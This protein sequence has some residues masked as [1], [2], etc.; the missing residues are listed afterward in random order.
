MAD[1]RDDRDDKWDVNDNALDAKLG[2]KKDEPANN[3]DDDEDLAL[4]E[5]ESA[6][7][8]MQVDLKKKGLL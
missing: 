4:K 8:L 6:D 5:Q 1:N 7:K 2:L 3:F